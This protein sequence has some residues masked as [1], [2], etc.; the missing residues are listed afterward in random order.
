MIFTVLVKLVL[1]PLSAKQQKS[2]VKM[3][4]VQPKLKELQDKYKNDPQKMQQE[5]M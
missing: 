4:Q 1:L 5:Q 2:M 3:Q